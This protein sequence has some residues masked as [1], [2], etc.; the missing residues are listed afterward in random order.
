MCVIILL[1]FLKYKINFKFNLN[2]LKF[3]I[4]KLWGYKCLYFIVEMFYLMLNVVNIYFLI[5]GFKVFFFGDVK[6][7]MMFEIGFFRFKFLDKYRY[8]CL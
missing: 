4:W 5:I 7:I 8:S 6:L 1:Y 2:E 3:F